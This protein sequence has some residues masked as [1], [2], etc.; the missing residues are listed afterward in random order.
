MR[1]TAF[2]LALF[3]AS[4]LIWGCGGSSEPPVS[5]HD[6]R[7]AWWR[8]ARFGL[9][10]HWGLYAIPAG[11]WDGQ[12]NHAEWIRTTARIPLETYDEFVGRFNPIKFDAEEWVRMAK[13]A[14]MKYIV[15]TSKHHDG[16]CLFDSEFTNFDVMSTPFGRDILKE[17]SQACRRAGL[18]MC[19][20]HS[21][22]DWHHPDYLPRRDWERDRSTKGADFD[23]YVRHMKNQLREL[24]TNYGEIGVLWFD[25]EWENSWSHARGKDLYD[26]VRGLQPSI[27]INNRVDVGRAG[28]QGLTKAGEYVG[29]FGTPEQEIPPTGLP[30]VD[31]ETCMTMNDH[32]GYNKNDRNWKSSQ[33]LV[34]MLADIASKGGNFLLNIGPTAEGVF[35]PESIERLRDIG[36]WMRVNGEAIYG[37]QAS[38]FRALEWGRCTQKPV[39]GGSRLYLHVFDWPEDG[40]LIVPGIYNSPRQAYLLSDTNKSRL[41]LARNEDAILITLPAEAPD[42]IDTVV[43]LDIEGKPDVSDP[44]SFVTDHDIFIDTLDIDLSSARENVEIRYTIDGSVPGA[45]SPLVK[46]PIRLTET[47]TVSARCFRGSKP[48]SGSASATFTRVRPRPSTS[49]EETVP[50]IFFAYYEGDWDRLPDFNLLKSA[51]QGEIE[52]FSFAPRTSEEHFGFVYSGFIR[53]P[54]DGVYAFFTESDDGSRL[55]IGDALVVDNDGLH[56]LA[57]KEGVIALAA[58]LHPIRVE[59]F[60]K[61]GGDGLTVSYEGPEISK[62]PIPS[63]ALS[64]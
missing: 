37:T 27:I 23:R 28:M 17:L 32:W 57:E 61:T 9:F 3:V 8:E 26:Y 58:G 40:R 15:I 63:D 29:D 48:V 19:W 45:E 6:A 55:Y 18:R 46:G 52:N 38:P 24:V 62:K 53:V 33:E 54:A 25:G 22:M 11:E 41:D 39:K 34:R 43:V 12:T 7:M 64:H 21:I 47:T 2:L 51:A 36:R 50:G 16:F 4:M 59:F 31:W 35:P 56:G 20:Y 42:P 14:G 49:V 30:G 13:D 1:K 60:E 10:I 44:P 5:E